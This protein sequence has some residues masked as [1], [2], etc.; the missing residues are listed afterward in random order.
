MPPSGADAVCRPVFYGISLFA[1]GFANAPTTLGLPD[2]PV[3]PTQTAPPF[4]VGIF[5]RSLRIAVISALPATAKAAGFPVAKRPALCRPEP[6]CACGTFGVIECDG[7][8]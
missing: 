4:F 5:R 3:K 1:I 6:K 2:A 7:C 8:S